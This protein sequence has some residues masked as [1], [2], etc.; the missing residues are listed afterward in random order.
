MRIDRFAE[1]LDAHSAPAL[2]RSLLLSVAAPGSPRC[3]VNSS[4]VP[5]G[6]AIETPGAESPIPLSR[7]LARL[8]AT[9]GG[10]G[11]AP[12]APGTAGSALAVLL[13][14]PL[15]S[16]SVPLY[17]VTVVALVFLGIW[18]A[19]EAEREFGQKDDRRI[20]IDEVAG[21]LITLA[22]LLWLGRARSFRWL[23]AG[24]LL[25]RLLDVWKPGVVGRCERSFS[26][27]VGVMLDDVAAG[28]VAAA[29][30]WL[31]VLGIGSAS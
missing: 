12:V 3:G 11:L 9:A 17:V 1:E 13:F 24:F 26:G 19:E 31:G 5:S 27:G 22:P 7:S 18:A 25:F 30:L 2:A 6:N 28:L 16:L 10:A 8:L 4:E 23:L 20:V 21:Q 29:A 15:S 14:L